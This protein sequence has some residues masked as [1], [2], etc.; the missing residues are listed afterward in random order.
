[1]H[2]NCKIQCSIYKFTETDVPKAKANKKGNYFT[3]KLH[4]LR[5]RMYPYTPVSSEI[6]KNF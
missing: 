5:H 4:A 1:M 3:C 6:N 2:F